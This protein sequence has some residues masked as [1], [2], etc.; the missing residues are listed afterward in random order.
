MATPSSCRVS[1]VMRRKRA[2]SD[3]TASKLHASTSSGSDS[4]EQL[5]YD[6]RR[7]RLSSDHRRRVVKSIESSAMAGVD[8]KPTRDV[9]N[10][11][12]EGVD[13]EGSKGAQLFPGEGMGETPL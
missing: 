5:E 13:D 12:R 6:L 7:A 2:A 11:E 1:S 9:V 4:D 8:E 3:A 10:G